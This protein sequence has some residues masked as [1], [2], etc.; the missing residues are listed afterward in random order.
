MEE[1]FKKYY[2]YHLKEEYSQKIY[3][4][5]LFSLTSELTEK[6]DNIDILTQKFNSLSYEEK[7][8]FINKDEFTKEVFLASIDLDNIKALDLL[9]KISFLKEEEKEL[10]LE[11]INIKT[12]L[13][14]GFLNEA[15]NDQYRY[16]R[17][18]MKYLSIKDFFQLYTAKK[19]KSFYS[20]RN[21]G[22]EYKLFVCLCEKNMNEVID[23]V[24]KDD[25][26][27]KEFFRL[28]DYFYSMFCNLD[29]DKLKKIVFKMENDN[30]D[31]RFDFVSSCGTENQIKLLN[32][33]L[34]DSTILKLLNYMNVDSINHF[35]QNNIRSKHLYKEVNI[36]ALLSNNVKFS[37]DIVKNKDFFDLL[38]S[39][40]F[41]VFR[42]NINNVQKNNDPTFIEERLKKYYEELITSYN[43]NTK[44]F[45]EYDNLLKNRQLIKKN[46]KND[47]I[48]SEDVIIKLLSNDD[49]SEYLKKITSDKLNEVIIDAIFNDNMYN[50]FLNIN[51]MLRFNETLL[52][53]ERILDKKKL[54][55]YKLILNIDKLDNEK[56]I[57]LYYK[58]KDKNY[59]YIFY[60]DLRR[61]KDLS[62]QKIDK[63]LFKL[64]DSYLDKNKSDKYG[65]KIYDLT[66][67]EYF[68]LVRRQHAFREK[69]MYVRGCY[70]LI[71]NENNNVFGGSDSD[72]GYLYGYCTF[73]SDK[74][75]HVL[76]RDSA[77]S[78]SKE[79][80]SR[81]VN[82]IMQPK[83]I[84]NADYGYSE[85]QIVNIKD[86]KEDIYNVKR[87][88]FLVVYDE[89]NERVLEEANR[90]NVP[91][92]IIK[93]KTLDK[94]KMLDIDFDWNNEIYV[95]NAFDE[96]RK[97]GKFRM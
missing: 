73:E 26:M 68:M 8:K 27:F 3:F 42:T 22:E 44:M 43:P 12:K 46:I 74:I 29:Y 24:L 13:Q 97:S 72:I 19:I 4:Y 77:S 92:A 47:F 14:E 30:L 34:K 80:A 18:V 25:Y 16:F 32:E 85:I 45:N 54:E 89:V 66:D 79:D 86:D 7:T 50:V 35:F 63:V 65:V 10:V 67:K 20:N 2:S 49:S 87:P 52:S 81:Y 70:S 57:E 53:D 76:E 82:R 17:E 83:E 71:S 40:S 33:E 58:L 37:D 41:V 9:K 78:S 62:Y 23:Y 94:D 93:E 36:P 59:N 84:V 91:I 48:L 11:D 95:S 28:N 51:E 88:E 15:K 96:D 1:K 5:D 64:E 39:E 56:K 55:F 60:E 21:N 61:L 38:K 6:L 31:Y 90:L 69:D 75:L